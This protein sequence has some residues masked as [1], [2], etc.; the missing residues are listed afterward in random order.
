[1]ARF[2]RNCGN[3]ITQ[4][5]EFCP[6]CG[7][8]LTSVTTKNH[9]RVCGNEIS[10]NAKF[11][12]NCGN[13]VTSIIPKYSV[14]QQSQGTVSQEAKYVGAPSGVNVMNNQSVQQMPTPYTKTLSASKTAGELDFGE[15]SVSE[16][17]NT[18]GSFTKVLS[19]VSGLLNFIGAFFKG[20]I[21]IF[22][23]PFTLIGVILI[24]ILWFVLLILRDSDS[25]IVKILSWITF[26]E[27]GF[28]RSV[29]G[30]IGGILG[31]GTVATALISLFN[32]GIK[33]LFRGIKALFVRHSNEKRGVFEILIGILIGTLLYFVFTGKHAS[34]L[35]L[36]PGISGILL[37][38]EALGG[39][40][41][42]LY[43]L[44]LSLTSGKTNGIRTSRQ[45]RCED[46]LTG[47]MLGFVIAI[48]VSILISFLN[49]VGGLL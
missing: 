26:S 8:A 31:K 10:L 33:D 30:T 32:G 7:Y 11:C 23:K 41:G 6:N 24:T 3:Q 18:S 5:G 40:K 2:C 45:G 47:L 25:L 29:I 1:M 27:G 44:A 13:P 43:I 39:G 21:D 34:I 49:I 48:V 35:T 42:K 37:S 4:D 20:F 38:L 9:C 36:M 19:P 14:N 12:R 15:L 28:D 46:F 16:L 17:S 22:H